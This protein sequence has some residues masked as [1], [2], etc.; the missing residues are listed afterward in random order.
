MTQQIIDE[1]VNLFQAKDNNT[2]GI[3][4]AKPEDIKSIIEIF[5]DIY[6]YNYLY[7]WIYDTEL[8]KKRLNNKENLWLI[9][10]SINTEEI[11]STAVIKKKNSFTVTVGKGAIK[12]KY[13]G[14][15][16]AK[17]LASECLKI[18]LRRPLFKNTLKIDMDVRANNIKAQ[19]W[20]EKVKCVP[21][22]FIPNY[23]NYADKRNFHS[24][25][26]EPFI[27]GQFE[28]VIMYIRPFTNLWKRRQNCIVMLD[29][30]D[31]IFFYN[32]VKKYNRRMRNDNLILKNNYGI[33]RES[34]KITEDIYKGILTINGYLCEKSLEGLL[35][36][37]SNWNV[38]EWRIPATFE[39]LNSQQIGLN[40]GF[41]VVGYD[42]GSNYDDKLLIDSVLMCYFPNGV[43]FT[44]FKG[45]NLIEKNRS[46]TKRVINSLND[47]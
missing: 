24:P 27:Q 14:I 3:R 20:A 26:G 8:F 9:G 17:E 41:K 33:K 23:N 19:K 35:K 5:K 1:Y 4:E 31:M 47:Y 12:K 39:G 40:K 34:F 38:I 21:Y 29:N 45:L 22:G 36:K 13:Q 46:L 42:P 10:V 18:S 43:D 30:E 28:S 15:G 11:I 44:Q 32:N 25:K 2:Y 7:P 16:I 37:Y 6:D